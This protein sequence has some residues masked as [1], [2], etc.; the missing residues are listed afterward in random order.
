[1]PGHV[2]TNSNKN[3][4][5]RDHAFVGK[6]ATTPPMG[7]QVPPRLTDTRRV[8]A[9]HARPLPPSTMGV[10]ETRPPPLRPD[11]PTTPIHPPLSAP[12]PK[13]SFQSDR[14]PRARHACACTSSPSP[15]GAAVFS[16]N[17][18]PAFFPRC[19][20]LGSVDGSLWV[21]T[22]P[23]LELRGW[24]G[25]RRRA[26]GRLGVS[27]DCVCVLLGGRGVVYIRLPSVLRPWL[28]CSTSVEVFCSIVS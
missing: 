6:R 28:S 23:S 3:E 17:L 24:C 27:R 20:P 15:M 4:Y 10:F 14:P 8:H 26:G 16:C 1:M 18:T 9:A 2:S 19:S 25:D 22:Y 13:T 11:E 5:H 7:I 21:P 12:H